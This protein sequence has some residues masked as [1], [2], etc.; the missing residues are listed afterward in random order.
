[1]LGP[2]ATTED[3]WGNTQ[4]QSRDFWVTVEHP[5]LDDTLTYPGPSVRLS[6]T[7]TKYWRRAPLIG[8]HNI[9]IYQKEMGLTKDELILLQQV[10]VI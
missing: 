4:L 9:E 10:K 7:P 3:L 5:E 8:E 1:M 6:E 2:L